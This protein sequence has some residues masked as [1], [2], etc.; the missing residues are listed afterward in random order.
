MINNLYMSL[1]RGLPPK[2][3]FEFLWAFQGGLD[4][5]IEKR[6]TGPI[7]VSVHRIA[8]GCMAQFLW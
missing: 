7:A 2:F 3:I 5:A 1:I 6:L 4:V 8:G